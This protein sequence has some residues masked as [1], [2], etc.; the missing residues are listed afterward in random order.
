MSEDEFTQF[1]V[2]QG[3]TEAEARALVDQVLDDD[4]GIAPDGFLDIRGRDGRAVEVEVDASMGF[5]GVLRFIVPGQEERAAGL[6]AAEARIA[7]VEAERDEARR[8]LA[9]CRGDLSDG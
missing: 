4:S 5:A 6:A 8:E 3:Y 1:L 9:R 7:E 2:E